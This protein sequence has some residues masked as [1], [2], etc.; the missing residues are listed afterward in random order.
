MSGASSPGILKHASPYN[1]NI[2]ESMTIT[3]GATTGIKTGSQES[4]ETGTT[5]ST[6]M[7]QQEAI[8]QRNLLESRLK[9]INLLKTTFGGEICRIP[10]F[11]EFEAGI[12]AEYLQK[13]R[14]TSSGSMRRRNVVDSYTQTPFEMIES[15]ILHPGRLLTGKCSDPTSLQTPSMSQSSRHVT[16]VAVASAIPS[17]QA[18][19]IWDSH[20]RQA[21]M[22]SPASGAGLSQ[23]QHQIQ[24]QQLQQHPLPQMMMLPPSTTTSSLMP[25]SSYLQRFPVRTYTERE[26]EMLHGMIMGEGDREVDVSVI[27]GSQQMQQQHPPPLSSSHQQ[28]QPLPIPPHMMMPASLHQA[29]QTLLRRVDP[30][31]EPPPL[32]RFR[33]TSQHHPQQQQQQQSSIQSQLQHPQRSISHPGHQPQLHHQMPVTQT[34]SVGSTISHSSVG[35]RGS[36]GP[37]YY[38]GSEDDEGEAEDVIGLEEDYSLEEH[39]RQM[40]MM[41]GKNGSSSLLPIPPYSS[42]SSRGR[43]RQPSDPSE[44]QRHPSSSR[45]HHSLVVEESASSDPDDSSVSSISNGGNGVRTGGGPVVYKNIIIT[46]RSDGSSDQETTPT[47]GMGER[48]GGGGGSQAPCPIHSV[49]QQQQRD[50]HY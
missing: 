21:W 29:Q 33:S 15:L 43:S 25:P 17:S 20:P 35:G 10:D 44:H 46:L 8:Q 40:M 1:S 38:F 26:S 6:Q 27:S 31:I 45:S 4:D 24:Q 14:A 37:G 18:Q 39:Q 22:I 47:Q 3:N 42:S 11:L 9:M 5:S 36:R 50:H 16:P 7:D 48:G 13:K 49:Q 30:V 12:K 34:P 41:E 32:L 23:Q 2:P 28:H 19:R